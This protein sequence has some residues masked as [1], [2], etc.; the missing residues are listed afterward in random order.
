MPVNH[1]APKLESVLD[2][3]GHDIVSGVIATGD[4]FTLHDICERFGIS[5]TVAREAMRAL[6]QLNLVAPP[7]A[8]D[9][10]CSPAKNGM[11]SMPR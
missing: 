7:A 1:A 10:R 6:E 4:R 3:L 8:S 2:E 11:F 9:S 5:R